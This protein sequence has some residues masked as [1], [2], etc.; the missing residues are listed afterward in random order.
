MVLL[1]RMPIRNRWKTD[2]DRL[3]RWD[4]EQVPN[5]KVESTGM[6]E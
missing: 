1:A 2:L 5:L 3:V 6:K 4:S